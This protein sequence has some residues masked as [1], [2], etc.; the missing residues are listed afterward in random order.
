[1]A[2]NPINVMQDF[3]TLVL[4]C[5]PNAKLIPNSRQMFPQYSNVSN[6]LIGT[7]LNMT[8]NYERKI[9]IDTETQ[10]GLFWARHDHGMARLL[11]KKT[12]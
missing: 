9:R 5:Q 8:I 2:S 11:K 10:L 1:M 7:M 3:V 4:H 12:N 6:S